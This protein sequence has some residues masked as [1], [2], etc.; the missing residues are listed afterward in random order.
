VVGLQDPL[1]RV[2]HAQSVYPPVN[3]A[4]AMENGPFIDDLPMKIVI[5]H[6]Y[7]FLPEGMTCKTRTFS[8]QMFP[9]LKPEIPM[10]FMVMNGVI[11]SINGVTTDLQLVFRATAD[12][13]IMEFLGEEHSTVDRH[14]PSQA[15]SQTNR[16]CI[17][18]ATSLLIRQ[19][20]SYLTLRQTH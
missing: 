3:I 16:F 4:I 2:W 18:N 9:H 19:W 8:L 1:R 12:A 17:N 20:I 14:F 15:D 10:I 6:S 11:D 13:E 5:F 7:G